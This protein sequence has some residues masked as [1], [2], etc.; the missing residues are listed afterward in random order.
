MSMTYHNSNVA[1]GISSS[2]KSSSTPP[3]LAELEGIV[4]RSVL[5]KRSL[6]ATRPTPPNDASRLL[7]REIGLLA[8]RSAETAREISEQIRHAPGNLG[9]EWR[10]ANHRK[11][12]PEPLAAIDSLNEVMHEI[13]DL[14]EAHL[15]DILQRPPIL[16]SMPSDVSHDIPSLSQQAAKLVQ[17]SAK[18]AHEL[19]WLRSRLGAESRSQPCDLDQTDKN[20]RQ[21]R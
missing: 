7:I 1:D 3:L 8:A 9:R 12:S 2:S 11:V 10:L 13:A 16:P 6:K 17:Q 15:R 18:L 4:S 5:L 21:S 14:S 20:G 19:E